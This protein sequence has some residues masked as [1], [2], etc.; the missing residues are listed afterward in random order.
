MAVMMGET[1]EFYGRRPLTPPACRYSDLVR[2]EA[3]RLAGPEG[4]RLWSYWSAALSAGAPPLALPTDRPRLPRQ[5]FAGGARTARLGIETG[6]RLQA[7][8]RRAGATPFM[9]LLAV[10]LVLLHRYGDQEDL[11]VGTPTSGRGS[12]AL[13]GVVGYLVNPVVVRGDLAGNPCFEALLARVSSAAVA[14]FAHAGLPFSLL[15]ERL[16]GERAPSRSPI[17]QAMFVLYQE[18]RRQ[19]RGLGALA[20]GEGGAGVE[21]AGLEAVSVALPRRSA[22]FDLTLQ[23]A[24]IR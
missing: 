19:D 11:L 23:G 7:L 2:W 8:G 17:F 1:G 21:L 6:A 20:L 13:A 5:S 14:A 16:G 3:E 18:R 22:Q 24:E 15:A 4:E 9:T 10:F 12:P